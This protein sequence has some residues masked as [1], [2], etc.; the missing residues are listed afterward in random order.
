M[1]SALTCRRLNQSSNTTF[2]NNSGEIDI[3]EVDRVV[4]VWDALTFVSACVQSLS[5]SCLITWSAVGLHPSFRRKALA[6]SESVIA[7]VP[8][9]SM[10]ESMYYGI[11][12]LCGVAHERTVSPVLIAVQSRCS[13]KVAPKKWRCDDGEHHDPQS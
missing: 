10:K 1:A 8:L 6:T 4:D 12:K 13:L 3:R 7:T 9:G 2:N 5:D 11:Y